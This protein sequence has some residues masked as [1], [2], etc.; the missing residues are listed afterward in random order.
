MAAGL[1]PPS[2]IFLNKKNAGNSPCGFKVAHQIS[3]GS[4]ERFKSYR[5]FKNA[6]SSML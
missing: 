2:W 1:R 5:N 3:K 6:N 4:V